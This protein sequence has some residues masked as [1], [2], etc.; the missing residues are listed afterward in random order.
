MKF[1]NLLVT[2]YKNLCSSKLE[3]LNKM[4]EFLNAYLEPTKIKES[5]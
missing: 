5:K 2:Y 1:R 3:N 4:D